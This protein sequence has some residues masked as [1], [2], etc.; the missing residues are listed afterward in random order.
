MSILGLRAHTLV[1]VLVAAV[2]LAA[3]SSDLTD[4]DKARAQVTAKEKAV[5]EAQADF[6]AAST[7]FC[8]ASEDYILALDRYGD[9]LTDSAVTVGDVRSAGKDLAAPRDE[10]FDTAKAAVAA[11]HTLVTAKQEL[12]DAEVALA[13]AEAGPSGE[14]SITASAVAPAEPLAPAATVDRVKQAE[15][16][17]SATASAITDDTP[18]RGAAEG[19]HSAAVALELSWLRLFVEGGCASEE[20]QARFS[21][22]ATAYTKALQTDLKAL[23]YYDDDIDGIYGPNT[24]KAVEDFQKEAGLDVTGTVDLATAEALRDA[25]VKEGVITAQE[26]F[27]TTAA[28][29]QTLTLLGYWD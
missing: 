19:F 13:A 22:E 20:Q 17:F 4:V 5:T 16:D 23:G 15:E 24:T 7:A 2:T 29:Q 26:T 3:C 8:G 21:E 11:Q 10:A 12:A 6:D 18:L 28:V 9:I 25:M 1:L 14:P 27:A